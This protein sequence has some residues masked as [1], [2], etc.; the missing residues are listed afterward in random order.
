MTWHNTMEIGWHTIMEIE[1]HS[2]QEIT[3][4]KIVEIRH[5]MESRVAIATIFRRSILYP[6][7]SL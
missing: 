2:I 5:L 3:W 7:P 4:H 6:A 1:W